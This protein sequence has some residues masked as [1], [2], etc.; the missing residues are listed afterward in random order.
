MGTGI[1]T[2]ITEALTSFV[3]SSATAIKD[4]L[5]NLL[6]VVGTDGS[7]SGLAPTGEVIFTIVGIGFGVGL[8]YVIFNL[9]RM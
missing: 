2:T 8:M 3:G 7:I 5:Q 6:F 4:G 1:V 9:F